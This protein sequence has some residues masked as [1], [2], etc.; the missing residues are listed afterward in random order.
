M[1]GQAPHSALAAKENDIARVKRTAA[2][3]E[4]SLLH[5]DSQIALFNDM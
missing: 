2:L 4:A 1:A 5:L 3:L